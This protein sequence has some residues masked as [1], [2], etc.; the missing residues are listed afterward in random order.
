[1]GERAKM[2][3]SI[4]FYRIARRIHALNVPYIPRFIDYLVR[5]LFSAWVPHKARIDAGVSLGYGGLGIVIHD[6]ARIGS[7]SEIDQG[8]T[9]GGNA[10]QSGA[11]VLGKFVYVGA[12]AKILGPI[13]IGD[14]VVIGA[15]AVVLMDI[16]ANCLVVGVPGRI[17]R[18]DIDASAFLFHR[19]KR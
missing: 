4:H 11:P 7:G 12:G 14:G 13:T 1:M 3:N 2:I 5:L 19:R 16:P 17:I 10:R 6:D 18:R 15:N 9:I 8:V